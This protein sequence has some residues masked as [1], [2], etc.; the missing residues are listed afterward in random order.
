MTDETKMTLA[1]AGRKWQ[2]A[3]TSSWHYWRDTNLFY[4]TLH[5]SL[6]WYYYFKRFSLQNVLVSEFVRSGLNAGVLAKLKVD[7][8]STSLLANGR[9]IRQTCTTSYNMHTTEY[10]YYALPIHGRPL[11]LKK[12]GESSSQRFKLIAGRKEE[13]TTMTRTIRF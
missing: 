4:V 10:A 2:T 7:R 11:E 13:E 9:D 3:Q 12:I 5:I 1:V 8:N 6:K